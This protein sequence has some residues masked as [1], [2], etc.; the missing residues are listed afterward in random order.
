MSTSIPIYDN[1]GKK[2]D[3]LEIED[4]IRFVNGRVSKGKE[5]YYKGL[6]VPYKQHSIEDGDITDDYEVLNKSDIFYLGHFV[7]K[8]CFQNKFGIFQERYMPKFTDFIGTCGT[9]ELSIIEN[10]ELFGRSSIELISS[11]YYDKS[12][13]QYYFKVRYKCHRISY[14]Q[15][16]NA[17]DLRE[18]FDYMIQNN[19]N[20][21]WDKRS[22][23]DIS[24]NGLVPDVADIFL[25]SQ[26]KSKV[27]SVYSVLYSLY[28]HSKNKYGDFVTYNNLNHENLSSIVFNVVE[29]LKRNNVDTKELL[30][31]KNQYENYKHIIRNYLVTGRNCGHCCLVDVGDDIKKEYIK[32]VEGLYK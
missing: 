17:K 14:L 8:K 2:I 15:N 22:I 12:N 25:D 24:Y 16:G 4:D 1:K 7:S 6:G 26:L 5:Y 10:S 28:N 11:H 21:N 9:K 32:Q 30:P 31:S 27:G 13:Q 23:T 20:F 29:I 18:L 19:W 3:S